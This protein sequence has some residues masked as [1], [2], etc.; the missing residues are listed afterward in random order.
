METM[1]THTKAPLSS[2][3]FFDVRGGLVVFLVALPLCLGIALASGAPLFSGIIAGIVGGIVIGSLIGSSLSVSGP[4]AGLTIMVLN[5]IQKLGQYDIFLLAVAIAGILQ[6]GLGYARAGVISNYFPTS[7]IK[8]ML[9]AI[10]LTLILK[11]IPHAL[12]YDRDAEGEFEF[13]QADGENTFTEIIRAFEA[14]NPA[15]LLISLVSIGILLLWERPALKKTSFFRNIPSALVVTLLGIFINYLYQTFA[16]SIALSG[17]HLVSLN[18]A[19]SWQGLASNFTF[20][21]FSQLNNPQVYIVAITLAVIASL[22]TLL[23]VEATDKLDPLRRH[24]SPNRELKAQGV[25][26]L[27]S[28]LIGGMPLTSVIVRSSVN[29][30][31]GSRTKMA[32]IIHGILLLVSVAFLS[33]YL[34]LIPLAALSAILLVTG[35][36]L[37]NTTL[38]K[39]TYKLG[40]SQFIPFLVTTVAVLFTDLLIGIGI[41]MMVGIFFILRANYEKSLSLQRS[42]EIEKE[43]YR[44]YLGENV[45]FL[46]KSGILEILDRIPENST[47]DIDG[48]NSLYIDHDVLE[49]IHNFRTTALAKNIKLNFIEPGTHPEE[50]KPILPADAPSSNG[51]DNDAYDRIF[52]NNRQ[53]VR[54]KLGLDPNYFEDLARGQSPKFLFIGCSDSRMPVS[55][56]TGTVPGEIFVHRNVANLVVNTD[57]NLLSVLQYAVE[58][59]KVQHV[60]VCGHYG[61]GGV[62]AAMTNQNLGL[63]NK[64]LRNIKDVYRLHREELNAMPNDDNRFKRLVELNVIEQVYNLH[65]TSIIQKAWDGQANLHVHGW[66]YDLRQGLIRDLNIEIEKAFEEYEQI[67][68]LNADTEENK[69]VSSKPATTKLVIPTPK[70]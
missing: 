56:I 2:T 54:E 55:E 62:K 26:N 18:I 8:G 40:W 29:I 63:I 23:N 17:N 58:V 35:Y 52:E 33:R 53:W 37:A 16:P 39:N 41:G 24:T 59:L 38:F 34:N 61:C 32:A 5:A 45:S 4:A 7:V 65:K 14:F 31:A 9:A 22:E 30:N 12:G 69:P 19:D 36:K 44:I 70:V 42:V 27:I 48:S 10:G 28:G 51:I 11:Q 25:G 43:H 21:D 46:N 13:I 66:V 6:I 1:N 57:L 3:L 20:P 15:A 47:L 64:W 68:K 49:L 50:S 60:V 67:Y